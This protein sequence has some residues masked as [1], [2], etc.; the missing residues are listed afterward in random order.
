MLDLNLLFGFVLAVVALIV[1]PG[2]V[3]AF[4]LRNA[5]SG[6][7]KAA[8]KSIFGTNAAS[9]ILIGIA[10]LV[11]LGM[12][13]VSPNLLNVIAIFGAV[14][15]IFLGVKG[16]KNTMQTAKT[17]QN[18]TNAQIHSHQKSHFLSGLLLGLSNP[19]DILFFTS[20]FPQFVAVT[21]SV[22]LSLAFL[23][24]VWIALDFALLFGYA[25]FCQTAVFGRH[26]RLICL[27]SDAVLLLVGVVALFYGVMKFV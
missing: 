13:S 3:V 1:T 14:F 15:I 25:L 20:F 18:K 27:L 16:L 9:L 6:G 19:K 12:F 10:S 8:L 7:L 17:T 26:K 22:H 21:P 11:L 24:L 23:T 4:V 5:A 2:P